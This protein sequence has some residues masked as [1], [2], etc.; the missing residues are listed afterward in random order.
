VLSFEFKLKN[1]V[2]PSL[3]KERRCITN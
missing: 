1:L 2:V 3:L